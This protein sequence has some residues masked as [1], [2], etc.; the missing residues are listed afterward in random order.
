MEKR[1]IDISTNSIIRIFAVILTLWFLYLVRDIV[2]LFFLSVILTATLD[3]IIR[4][5]NRKNI[6]RS[7]SVII[8]YILLFLA[9]GVVLS[10][11]IPPLISQFKEFVKNLPA[12][13][14]SFSSSFAGIEQYA[15]SY[16]ISFN[17]HEFL[18]NLTGNLFQ[19]SGQFFGATVSVL[20]F[21]I[22][23]LVVLA[24]TFYMSVKRTA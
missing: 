5:L 9:V 1:I 7:L 16:G 6:S 11:L 15:L 20:T 10:F 3:P 18:Q 21:F 14:E 13:S 22:S 19:S 2:S 12:Y 17:S 4:L 8:I 23:L 24:L